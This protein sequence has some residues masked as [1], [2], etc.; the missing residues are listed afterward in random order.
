MVARA[1]SLSSTPRRDTSD[2]PAV[3]GL[4][5]VPFRKDNRRAQE[6]NFFTVEPLKSPPPPRRRISGKSY[7]RAPTKEL[8]CCFWYGATAP[9][10]AMRTTQHPLLLPIL[11]SFS[12]LTPRSVFTG[13]SVC[14]FSTRG[15]C[16]PERVIIGR[17]A[18][19]PS[20]ASRLVCCRSNVPIAAD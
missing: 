9:H 15:N 7:H 6:L 19:T 16:W 5:V 11:V 4:P 12:N 2:F 3:A 14:V 10:E 20:Y 13:R 8:N 17:L 18:E 1:S